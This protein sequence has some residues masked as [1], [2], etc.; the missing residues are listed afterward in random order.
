MAGEHAGDASFY[1]FLI[2]E[3][4]VRSTPAPDISLLRRVRPVTARGY[5]DPE[6][7]LEGPRGTWGVDRMA[8][9]P[10]V[11]CLATVGGC[12]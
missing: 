3:P 9:D 4:E 11:G 7:C 8:V 2:D 10:A 6:A 5:Q 12:V 1:D